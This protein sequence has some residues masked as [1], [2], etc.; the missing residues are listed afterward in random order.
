MATTAKFRNS[1]SFLAL[2]EQ[3]IKWCN[4]RQNEN[5]SKYTAYFY[6]SKADL[7]AK[8]NIISHCYV[9]DDAAVALE[10]GKKEK[11]YFCE[12][13]QDDGGTWVPLLCI[14]NGQV[15]GQKGRNVLTIEL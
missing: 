1:M 4:I 7:E 13:S 2:R 5:T 8:K 3:G 10:E 9:T 11:V 6:A 15:T 12:C 14:G